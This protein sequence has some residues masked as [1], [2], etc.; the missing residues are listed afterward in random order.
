MCQTLRVYSVVRGEVLGAVNTSLTLHNCGV[1]AHKVLSPRFGS[2]FSFQVLYDL[3]ICWRNPLL[4]SRKVLVQTLEEIIRALQAMVHLVPCS[5]IWEALTGQVKE[6]YEFLLDRL[7]EDCPALYELSLGYFYRRYFAWP[8]DQ[9]PYLALPRHPFKKHKTVRCSDKKV[10]PK[11]EPV[12]PEEIVLV[13]D[14]GSL[15][16]EGVGDS[17]PCQP[18]S[19]DILP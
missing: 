17:S 9:K 18:E 12:P 15:V 11:V 4:K 10:S 14:L 16:E 8:E 2:E 7:Q 13:P 6:V 3:S 5:K 1:T 19:S